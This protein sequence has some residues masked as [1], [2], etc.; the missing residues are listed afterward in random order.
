MFSHKPNIEH[1]RK[2]FCKK[3]FIVTKGKIS[4]INR[5]MKEFVNFMSCPM[6][7]RSFTQ[8]QTINTSLLTITLLQDL[9]CIS[10]F[11]DRPYGT[12]PRKLAITV[13]N[14]TE[15]M[16]II[17]SVMASY[18]AS[19]CMLLTRKNE[20]EQEIHTDSQNWLSYLRDTFQKKTKVYI[21]C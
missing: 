3:W 9:N 4:E 18:T 8:L 12:V 11:N 6:L 13:R 19:N 1:A 14:D 17:M 16:G 7:R 20:R 15:Y 10:N 21:L 5:S 2:Q